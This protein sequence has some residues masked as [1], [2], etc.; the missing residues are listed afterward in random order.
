M[1]RG[2]PWELACPSGEMNNRGDTRE[3]PKASVTNLAS[4]QGWRLFYHP[5]APMTL[6]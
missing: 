6:F 5:V 2:S 1:L 3:V 4:A